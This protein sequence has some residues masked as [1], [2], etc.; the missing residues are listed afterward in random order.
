MNEVN[1][2]L[3]TKIVHF[4]EDNKKKSFS[5]EELA[6]DLGLNKSADFKLLV[7][8]VA[9]MEREKLIVFNKKGKIKLPL[10]KML[11][12]GVFRSNERGFGFVT[13]DP[14]EDDVYI[15][16][17][18]TN[19]AMDGDTVAIE[20]KHPAQPF[21]G[22]GAEGRV[23]EVKERAISQIVGEFQL[24]P[25]DEI[26]AT[27]LYGMVL[28]KNKKLA[29]FKVMV[30]AEGIRPV[31][32]SIVIVELS[33]YPEKGY[34][35][36]LEGIVKSVVGHKDEPGMDILSVLVANHVPTKFPE[37][38]MKEA[39][40]MPDTIEA[41]AYPERRDLQELQM[42]TIDGESAKD[43]DDAV[44]VKKL[45]NGH[46][47]LNVSIADV[48]Y[49]VTENSALDKEAFERG[50]SVYLTDRVVPMLPPRLSN[51]ICSLNPQVARLAMTCEM[52]IDSEGKVLSHNIYPSVIRTDERMTYTAV[53]QILAGD[54]TQSEKYAA[55]VPMFYEMQELH[56][57]LANMRHDRGALTF[58]DNEA[59]ILVDEQ[60]HPQ[61]IV[62]RQR[63]VGEKMIE[64]FMLS[65]N[66]T[67]AK[68]YSRLN[69]PF[70]YRIHEDP[71]EE[72]L[73]NFFDFAATLGIMAKNKKG[74]IRPRDLQQIVEKSAEKPES[75]VIN[76]MMLRSMQQARYSEENLGHYGLAA[77]YYTHFTSPIRRYP[78]LLVHRLIR[79]YRADKS[80]KKQAS[81]AKKIPE[82]A[83]HSSQMERRAVDCER[84]VDNMKKAEYM[85]DHLDEVFEGVISSVV[86][87]GFFVELPNT[88]EGLIHVSELHSDY[89]QFVE[90]QLALVGERTHRTFKIGQTVKVRV[91]K[92]DP[93]TREIDFEL[94]ETQGEKAKA[95]PN[96]RKRRRKKDQSGKKKEKRKDKT[97]K[98]GKSK[99]RPFYKSAPKKKGKK[100]G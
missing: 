68:H 32:G 18:E 69:L 20:I 39:D 58:E 42:V 88:I 72:K 76:M 30:A 100:H 1:E 34:P 52:E 60:G 21:D 25:E 55:L 37:E 87:F 84:D 85:A 83:T 67:V 7:Q 63:G 13:I 46:F 35:D 27:D 57:I 47:Y 5:M 44:A 81:W 45:T 59:E 80:K 74:R 98:K 73:M 56:E 93:E 4:M 94:I 9:V 41:A 12:E 31:D 53:N 33:H 14:E 64:S 70:I 49:Y 86:K 82:I 51:G 22:K 79:S 97:S 77:E 96:R 17:E 3:K 91:I 40:S 19:Y 71:K 10:Q 24:F 90:N 43:L 95:Q 8:T 99:Q 92:A 54:K 48:S 65:A 16:K 78:D 28:P 66:E 75:T 11:L 36:T 38:V 50:T 2:N 62:M 29:A 23:V 15:A 89:Y 6:Q 61:E 26:A